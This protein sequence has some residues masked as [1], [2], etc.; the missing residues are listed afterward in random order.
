MRNARSYKKRNVN[1]AIDAKYVLVLLTMLVFCASTAGAMI[2]YGNAADE[3]LNLAEKKRNT[4][5]TRS[6]EHQNLTSLQK[7]Y[8]SADYIV[9]YCE[10]KKLGLRAPSPGQVVRVDGP[11]YAERADSTS[12]QLVYAYVE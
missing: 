2:Y 4:I 3:M 9:E 12:K 10:Q 1:Q 5:S 7:K 8:S 11:S 6:W